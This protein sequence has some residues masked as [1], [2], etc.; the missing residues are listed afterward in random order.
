VLKKEPYTIEL[1]FPT[2]AEILKAIKAQKNN[3]AS[4]QDALLQEIY[5]Q[6]REITVKQLH[7]I[8]EEP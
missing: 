3:K 7:D 4:G 8:L 5:K 1:A 6:C 2:T